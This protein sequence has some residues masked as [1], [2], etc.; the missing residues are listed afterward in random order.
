MVTEG[1]SE[2]GRSFKQMMQEF[3][4]VRVQAFIYHNNT[5]AIL[6]SFEQLKQKLLKKLEERKTLSRVEIQKAELKKNNL[7]KRLVVLEKNKDNAAID[8]II[9]ELEE[10]SRIR[11]YR[12][13]QLARIAKDIQDLNLTQEQ[14]VKKVK[15]IDSG[16]NKDSLR[17]HI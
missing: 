4:D 11:R 16:A 13:A 2:N 1:A 3:N 12:D 9:K 17:E 10:Y 15:Q 8:E 14:F 6:S 7:V 5:A